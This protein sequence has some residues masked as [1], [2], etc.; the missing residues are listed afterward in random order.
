MNGVYAA[1]DREPAG[2]FLSHCVT[3]GAGSDGFRLEMLRYIERSVASGTVDQSCWNL[4][5]P[6]LS[7]SSGKR[8][9]KEG[10]TEEALGGWRQ[11]HQFK[12]RL[13]AKLRADTT[14]TV[15]WIAER[16]KTGSRGHLIYLLGQPQKAQADG[17][18]AH[19]PEL[20]I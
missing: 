9:K 12:I 16:L 19:Q 8:C 2:S 10:I 13:A 3:V 17:P 1:T 5:G 18:A 14:M 6:K 11:R 7:G 15:A 20:P 4:P